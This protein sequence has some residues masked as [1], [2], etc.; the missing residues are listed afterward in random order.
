MLLC[1]LLIG[2]AFCMESLP[3]FFDKVV[4]PAFAVIISVI[5]IVFAGEVIPQALCT[6]PKQLTIAEKLTPL[7]KVVMILFWPISYPLSRAL[8]SYF[9]EHSAT[10]FKK[11]ELKALI[12]LHGI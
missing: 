9:G 4:P 5:F 7:V 8:D 1:T 11:N 6:G 2:N 10:R 12:E 3:I